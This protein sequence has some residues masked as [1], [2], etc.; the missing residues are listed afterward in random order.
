MVRDCS[1]VLK[2]KDALI[3]CSHFL[4]IVV[5]VIIVTPSVVWSF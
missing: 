5:I 4:Y 3:N 1:F 2:R